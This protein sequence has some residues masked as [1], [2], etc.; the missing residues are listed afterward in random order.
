VAAIELRTAR[1]QF[2]LMPRRRA[3]GDLP[4]PALLLDLDVLERNLTRMAERTRALGVAL[5]PHVKTHK[6]LEVGR[7]QL[8]HGAVGI[9]V[10]TL[11]EAAAFAAGG[12]TDITWAFP[13]VLARLDEVIALARRVTLRVLLDSPDALDALARAAR[14]AGIGVHAWLEVDTG[15]HRSGV[16]PEAGLG[17]ARRLATEEGVVFD[18]VLTHAGQSYV[19]RTREERAAVA[20]RE[21]ATMVEFA[22]ALAAAGVPVPAVSVGST[23]AMSAVERLD[24]VTEVRPG[25]YAFYDYMQAA[26]GVCA[27][28]DCALT[29]LASVVSHQP[30]AAHV[31]V[32][33]GALVLSKDAGP[34]DPGLG[35]G[36]G[37]VLRGL[38]GH[39]LEPFAQV[40]GVSQEH[41][42]VG[43]QS[44]ADVDGRFRVGEKLRILPNHSCLTAAM[45]D[46]YDVVRAGEVVDTWRIWRD[47]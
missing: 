26:V 4:T 23:P 9:T 32:D 46:R 28:A 35:R 3:V 29:V 15:H 38:E 31:V 13:L 21:R 34:H 14:G 16:R 43:G 24:G 37:P 6:C 25:N 30:G 45:F 11:P 39:D 5:R 1:R 36:L 18:G 10:A 12:F 27:P 42:T 2:R 7:R 8:A 47:R 40:Q 44:A 22:A 41:G 19:A 20:E 17:L 33:A